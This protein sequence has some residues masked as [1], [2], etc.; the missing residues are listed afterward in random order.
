[1]RYVLDASVAVKWFLR[2]PSE[3]LAEESIALLRDYVNGRLSLTV[4]DLFWAEVGNILWKAVKQA[5][6]TADGAMDSI[7]TLRS[8]GIAG[9]SNSRLL[10]DAF[11]IATAF[12]RS[13]YDALYVALA[14]AEGAPLITADERLV[15]ALGSRFPVK[16]LGA[17][18]A[19]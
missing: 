10:E 7:D 17:Y 11:A 15:N 5:R 18:P 12:D 6:I 14:V 3:T 16:W 19:C 8:F 9:V 1:M 2:G 4:P 13:V